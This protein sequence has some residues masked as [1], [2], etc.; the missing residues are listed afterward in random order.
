MT[1]AGRRPD[2]LAFLALPAILLV[3]QVVVL[4]PGSPTLCLRLFRANRDVGLSVVAALALARL[5]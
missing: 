3:R 1:A 4:D 2:T 5:V